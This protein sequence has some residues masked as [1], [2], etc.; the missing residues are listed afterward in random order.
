M[1]ILNK[2]VKLNELPS[3]INGLIKDGLDI[4]RVV[5]NGNTGGDYVLVEY[6]NK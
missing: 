3:F 2:Q 1:N 5:K 6:K 4:T